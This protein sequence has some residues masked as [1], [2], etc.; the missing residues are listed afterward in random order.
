MAPPR[1]GLGRFIEMTLAI[2]RARFD[3][4]ADIVAMLAEDPL[5]RGRETLGDPLPEHYRRAF[6]AIDG[7]PNHELV[8]AESGRRV[9]ATLQL[10]FL[11]NLTYGGGWR[12]Q[13]EGVRVA[14]DHRGRGVGTEIIGWAI[15]RARQKAC[16][17]V[18]LTAD[19]KRP[20][21]IRFY[22]SLGFEGSHE[23]M[24]LRLARS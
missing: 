2:R 21:A 16:V 23:G 5:G 13:I 20:E 12:A 15:E 24:K 6:T 14:R 17:L 19:K 8:V 4:L 3:D 11:P 7:D 1:R 9:I 22:E 18:Q 10:S